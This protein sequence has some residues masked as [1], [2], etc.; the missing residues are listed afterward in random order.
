MKSDLTK[1]KEVYE[2]YKGMEDSILSYN[3]NKQVAEIMQDL[4]LVIKLTL[5]HKVEI[6]KKG[7]K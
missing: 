1:I 2:K 7:N 6:S 3:G 5:G 4:W